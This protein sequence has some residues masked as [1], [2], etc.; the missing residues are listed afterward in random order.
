MLSGI[1]VEVAKE[2]SFCEFLYPCRR[3]TWQ[4]FVITT[5]NSISHFNYNFTVV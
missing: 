4:V 1:G 5:S 3:L 2:P